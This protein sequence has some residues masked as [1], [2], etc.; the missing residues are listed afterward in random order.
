M[1]VRLGS[2]YEPH[3][4]HVVR[5]VL[6]AHGIP[7]EVWHEEALHLYTPGWQPCSVM[8]PEEE[9]EAALEVMNARPVEPLLEAG[10]AEEAPPVQKYPAF[11]DW[12]LTFAA[13]LL[14]AGIA[15]MAGSMLEE[16]EGHRLGGYHAGRIS[17][18]D[19]MLYLVVV[20]PVGGVTAAAFLKLCMAPLAIWNG[21]RWM[22]M[23]AYLWVR[24]FLFVVVLV[25]LC[26]V[27]E[28][29]RFAHR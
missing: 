14:L 16:L 11:L 24:W 2:A 4:A 10:A 8:I 1:F 3:R 21:D 17:A 6:E 28:S 9:V 5:G 27:L 20:V 19:V 25:A 23:V 29:L 13:V 22:G 15:Q 12:A 7:V 26:I 18:A